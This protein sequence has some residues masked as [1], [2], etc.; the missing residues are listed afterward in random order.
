MVTYTF[1]PL[2][3]DVNNH[4]IFW[5]FLIGYVLIVGICFFAVWAGSAEDYE[6][7]SVFRKGT[8]I[9]IITWIIS[10]KLTNQETIVYKNEKVIGTI[11]GFVAEGYSQQSG[12]T[13]SDVHKQFVEYKVE[14]GRVLFDA[15]TETKYLD[16]IYLYK[17]IK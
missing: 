16:R 12:K 17:N 6:F 5:A 8:V 15:N 7:W 1:H 9:M 10:F 13:R 3:P 4:E 11:V 2:P 14:G